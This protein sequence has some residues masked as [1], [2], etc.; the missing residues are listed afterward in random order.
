ML[1]VFTTVCVSY[2]V[3]R[4]I[5]EMQMRKEIGIELLLELPDAELDALLEE[6]D[7]PSLSSKQNS[8]LRPP[9][10]YAVWTN[11]AAPI[12]PFFLCPSTPREAKQAAKAG[13]VVFCPVSAHSGDS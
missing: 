13:Q 7:E 6:T 1:R 8:P 2:S 11:G 12:P 3:P 9:G 4:D 5:P 10:A